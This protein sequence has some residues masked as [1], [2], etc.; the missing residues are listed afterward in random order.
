MIIGAEFNEAIRK[1][2]RINIVDSALKAMKLSIIESLEHLE[3][4][5][6]ERKSYISEYT[7]IPINILTPLLKEL[8]I[9]GKIEIIMIWS[10][11]TLTPNG[12]GYCLNIGFKET[13]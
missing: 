4:M 7:G 2:R 10:E 3:D 9:E 11:E 5:Y 1:E 13:I 12:S 8:K 6:G